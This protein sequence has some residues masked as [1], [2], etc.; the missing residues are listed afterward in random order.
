MASQRNRQTLQAWQQHV[1]FKSHFRLHCSAHAEQAFVRVQSY[2]IRVHKLTC[3]SKWRV[4][5]SQRANTRETYRCHRLF[6]SSL[7]LQRHRQEVAGVMRRWILCYQR[8][9]S[10]IQT[11]LKLS[12][13]HVR[14]QTQASWQTWQESCMQAQI[15]LN[16]CLFPQILK[17]TPHSDNM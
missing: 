5:A 1:A 6:S 13:R 16:F 11:E 14:S 7:T 17:R 12:A 15:F 2:K 8:T 9:R 4:F 3:V 10:L